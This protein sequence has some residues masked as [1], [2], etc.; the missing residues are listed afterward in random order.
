M[1][2]TPALKQQC[3][4]VH[5]LL[6][7][8]GLCARSQEILTYQTKVHGELSLKIKIIFTVKKI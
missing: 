7:I 8:I 1:G 3:K 5:I 2:I 4:L 6:E